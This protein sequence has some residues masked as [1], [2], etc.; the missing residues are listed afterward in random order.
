MSGRQGKRPGPA[1]AGKEEPS[2]EARRKAGVVLEVLAGERT[3]GEAAGALAM[4]TSGYYLLEQRALDALVGACE[5]KPPGR[6]ATG[7]PTVAALQKRCAQLERECARWQ[8]LARAAQRSLGIAP[9]KKEKRKDKRKPTRRG[10]AAAKRLRK[11]AAA[12]DVPP[13]QSPPLESAA[14]Q[15]GERCPQDDR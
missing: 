10:L 4:S 9:P 14:E 8:G 11:Q 13:P 7:E 2:R 6:V 15:G 5:P 12:P 3:P 1:T